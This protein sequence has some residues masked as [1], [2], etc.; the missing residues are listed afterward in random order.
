MGFFVASQTPKNWNRL[1]SKYCLNVCLSL[2]ESSSRWSFFKKAH[3]PLRDCATV[4]TDILV[5]F[6]HAHTWSQPLSQ[7]K[8]Y[9]IVSPNQFLL[10]AHAH[11]NHFSQHTH[12]HKA[13][14]S[15]LDLDDAHF[16]INETSQ[17]A[18]KRSDRNTPDSAS[19]AADASCLLRCFPPCE[20]QRGD[21][22]QR[23]RWARLCDGRRWSGPTL[24]M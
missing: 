18:R 19:W 13:D 9:T 5:F 2:L 7:D 3:F 11:I 8:G 6:K 14:R 12:T 22:T 10:S 24:T 20:T 4:H 17:H 16:G 1:T 21:V 15:H 23:G